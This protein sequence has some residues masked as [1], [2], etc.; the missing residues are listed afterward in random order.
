[1]GPEKKIPEPKDLLKNL[2]QAI[3]F[4]LKDDDRWNR[5]RRIHLQAEADSLE[6]TTIWVSC[7][8]RGSLEWM[9]VKAGLINISQLIIDSMSP[10]SEVWSKI[11]LREILDV[12]TKGLLVL[13]ARALLNG[14]VSTRNSRQGFFSE[15]GIFP[16]A[17][18]PDFEPM[19]IS[20]LYQETETG[21]D[22]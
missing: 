13:Q 9:T 10:G 18:R 2:C 14:P 1:M 5:L 3:G 12:A 11:L 21:G 16:P 22:D 6:A 20:R 7:E 19:T 4:R 15:G 17:G 8:D